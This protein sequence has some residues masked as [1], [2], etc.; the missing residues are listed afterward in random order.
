MQLL[1]VQSSLAS[2][3]FLSLNSHYIFLF[4]NPP[5]DCGVE[6]KDMRS[7]SLQQ[8]QLLSFPGLR[9]APGSQLGHAPDQDMRFTGT[10]FDVC[11]ELHIKL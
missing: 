1:T 7:L 4:R 5:A 11:I 10:F 9:P 8:P 3:H 6:D 2:H